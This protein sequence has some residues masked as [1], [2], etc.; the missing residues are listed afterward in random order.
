MGLHYL[1][2]IASEDNIRRFVELADL[3]RGRPVC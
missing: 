3:V 2:K 1:N